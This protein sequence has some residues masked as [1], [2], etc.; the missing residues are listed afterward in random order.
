MDKNNTSSGATL[1]MDRLTHA[2]ILSGSGAGSLARRIA[3]AMVCEAASGRPCGFCRHCRK[4]MAGIHPDIITTST[5]DGRAG[6]LVGQAR[7]LRSDAYVVPNEADRKVYIIDPADKMNPQAQNALL[8]VL[9]EPPG[10]TSFL[11]IAENTSALLET[12]RSRCI[13][14]TQSAGDDAPAPNEAARDFMSV[15]ETG[16]TLSIAEAVLA[17]D[18]KDKSTREQLSALS[19]GMQTLAMERL[20]NSIQQGG[21]ADFY[22]EIIQVFRRFDDHIAANVSAGNL[23]ALLLSQFAPLPGGK[24]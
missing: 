18:K 19:Q 1:D 7:S 23:V 5:Q 11:L 17:L 15:L 22:V 3:A 6:I 13:E 8:K 24:I 16:N 2:Y 10:F 4:A 14:V 12:V 20:K 21:R 9:E